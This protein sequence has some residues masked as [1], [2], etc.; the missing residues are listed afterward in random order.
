MLDDLRTL[1]RGYQQPCR[2][3]CTAGPRQCTG[4]RVVSAPGKRFVNTSQKFGGAVIPGADHNPVRMQ[5]VFDCGPFT[6]KFRV[7]NYVEALGIDAMTMQ[8]AA[9]PLVG[10]DRY[11]ALFND[12]LITADGTGNL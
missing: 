3:G 7:G 2:A 10:I 4:L 11:R 12:N 5:K 6:Q 8:H 1:R 9:D